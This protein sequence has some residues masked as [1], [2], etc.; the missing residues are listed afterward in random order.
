MNLVFTC[1]NGMQTRDKLQENEIEKERE[2][3]KKRK[4]EENTY[5][6]NK[7]KESDSLPKQP[8]YTHDKSHL[9]IQMNFF[10]C[11]HIYGIY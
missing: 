1:S 4:K 10:I 2:R 8:T 5:T 3:E 7:C 11:I 6:H 9:S